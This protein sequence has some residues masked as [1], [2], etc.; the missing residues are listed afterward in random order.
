MGYLPDNQFTIRFLHV[1]CPVLPCG[2][3]PAS[4][5]VVPPMAGRRYHSISST[6]VGCGLTCEDRTVPDLIRITRSAMA[7][8]AW[9]WVMTMTVR[10]VW[11]QVS[12]SSFSTLLPVL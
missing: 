4:Q 2:G 3:T 5:P 6:G 1:S 7:V 12:C 10:P 9:L 11:R 8:R